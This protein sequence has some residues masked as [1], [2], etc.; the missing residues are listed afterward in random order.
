MA[1]TVGYASLYDPPL[2]MSGSKGLSEELYNLLKK[3]ASD[4]SNIV[5]NAFLNYTL[6]RVLQ[7]HLRQLSEWLH[8]I[9]QEQ[10]SDSA[11]K[12]SIIKFNR[13]VGISLSLAYTRDSDGTVGL[14]N[15]WTDKSLQNSPKSID[16]VKITSRESLLATVVR[17][18]GEIECVEDVDMLTPNDIFGRL[19][20]I[21]KKEKHPFVREAI[22]FAIGRQARRHFDE[23]EPQLQALVAEV[24][25]DE[26]ADIVNTLSDIYF[27]QRINLS[28]GD[29]WSSQKSTKGNIPYKYQ[30]WT[31][32]Q[33]PQTPIED[34][35]YDWIK[36]AR[37]TLLSKSQLVLWLLLSIG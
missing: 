5:R 9:I 25:E 7:M 33:R 23:I 21:L 17:T 10:I 30:I 34:A 6:P 36:N 27:E 13:A 22:L 8:D 29:Y 3:L 11:S 28:G 16:A 35:M 18:Y 24:K 1:L 37:N 2:G 26:R 12:I 32:E 31:N 19:H 15:D 4:T 14:L 20:A